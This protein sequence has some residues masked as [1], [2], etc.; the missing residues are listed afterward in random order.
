MGPSA[1]LTPTETAFALSIQARA[2]PPRSRATIIDRP[3]LPARLDAA[4]DRQVVSIQAPAGFGKTTLLGQAL[5]R[6]RAQQID[7]AWLTVDPTDG[8]CAGF[9][10]NL[11]A[12]L[13]LAGKADRR[14]WPDELSH[15]TEHDEARCCA[16]LVQAL[17]QRGNRVVL[18]LDDCQTAN[19]GLFATALERLMHALPDNVRIV[20]SGR[21]RPQISL[22]ELR[23]RGLVAEFTAADFLF[24]SQDVQMLFGN[25]LVPREIARA[26]ARTQGWPAMLQLAHQ[27]G[28]AGAIGGDKVAMHAV[29]R[30]YVVDQIVHPMSPALREALAKCSIFT[31]FCEDLAEI[32]LR[33]SL[34]NGRSH[35]DCQSRASGRSGR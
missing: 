23:A 31:Q 17:A 6:F 21:W 22:S 9:L 4:L 3:T 24:S 32:D 16:I 8:I 5:A 15:L 34:D 18:I 13:V 26:L 30:E 1:T 19:T 2:H 28:D 12:A 7:W 10:R 33:R 20:I 35:G 25:P 14:P 11:A 27:I 29:L